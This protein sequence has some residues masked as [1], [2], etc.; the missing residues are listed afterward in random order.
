[1]PGLVAD[2]VPSLAEAAL[3]P[4]AVAF[5][6]ALAAAVPAPDAAAAILAAVADAVAGTGKGAK[7]AKPE[8]RVPAL[9]VRRV[10]W[11][12]GSLYYA[13]CPVPVLGGPT[14]PRCWSEPGVGP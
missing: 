6:Q 13:T 12:V 10:G 7:I 3:S 8:L 2:V 9:Q 14:K 5:L 4:A 1:M 11:P